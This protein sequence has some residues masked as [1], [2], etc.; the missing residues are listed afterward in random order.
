MTVQRRVL[1]K[2]LQETRSHPTA[3]DLLGMVRGDLPKVSLGTVYRNLDVLTRDG[4]VRKLESA[5]GHARFDADLRPHQ[6]VRCEACGAVDD[7][8]GVKPERIGLPQRSEH[9]FA[10]RELKIEFIGLCADCQ[11]EGLEAHAQ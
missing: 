7:V 8:F 5:Q 6:H 1:L 9:G 11:Q 3:E 10:I 4:V 2:A